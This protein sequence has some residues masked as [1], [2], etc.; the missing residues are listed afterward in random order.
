MPCYLQ[1]KTQHHHGPIL[2]T[3]ETWN[4]CCEVYRKTQQ[5]QSETNNP[6]SLKRSRVHHLGVHRLLIA[7][8]VNLGIIIIIIF[9]FTITMT[10]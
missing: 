5:A 7:A 10:S 3:M 9:N 2:L 1:L 8:E 6:V 4:I